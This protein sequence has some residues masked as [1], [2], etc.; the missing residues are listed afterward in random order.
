MNKEFHHEAEQSKRDNTNDNEEDKRIIKG[1]KTRITTK[2]KRGRG[3]N[4]ERAR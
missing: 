4:R 2:K 3:N 1:R